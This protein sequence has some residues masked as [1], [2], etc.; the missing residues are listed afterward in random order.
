MDVTPDNNDIEARK[1][2]I[3]K[4]RKIYDFVR[5]RVT[6]EVALSKLKSNRFC[7]M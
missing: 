3:G 5:G 4:L 2:G 1:Y 7:L 6:L